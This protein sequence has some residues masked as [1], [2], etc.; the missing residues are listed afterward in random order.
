MKRSGE[1]QHVYPSQVGFPPRCI[2]AV[3]AVGVAPPRHRARLDWSARLDGEHRRRASLT[4][5]PIRDGYIHGNAQRHGCAEFGH[6]CLRPVPTHFVVR[7]LKPGLRF[8]SSQPTAA[9]HQRHF[10]N[11]KRGNSTRSCP[12]ACDCPSQTIF[13]VSKVHP[14][15]S[16]KAHRRRIP[17][18]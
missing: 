3:S 12:S 14:W 4:G 8:A 11:T 9:V 16:V 17:G 5:K 18:I 13:P 10:H 6:G 2:P 15:G 7:N 1:S